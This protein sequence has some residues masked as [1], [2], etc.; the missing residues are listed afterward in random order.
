MGIGMG[1]G[2]MGWDA[3]GWDAHL[4]AQGRREQGRS[5]ARAEL[6]GSGLQ[7]GRRGAQ[8]GWDVIDSREELSH[9]QDRKAAIRD[10]ASF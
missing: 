9:E 3:M 5:G 1:M 4:A 7:G 8:P 6:R 10:R 2:L